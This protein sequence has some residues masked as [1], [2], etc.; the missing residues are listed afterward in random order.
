MSSPLAVAA[1]T[2]TFAQL[3]SRVIEDTALSG[4]N[5]TTVPPDV[6]A[7]SGTDRRLNLFLYQV[8]ADAAMRNEPLPVRGSDGRLRQRPVTALS[9]HYLVTAFGDNNDELD[10]HHL[11]AHAMSL[12]ND[13]P[14]LSP[15]S[16]K[17]AIAAEARVAGSDLPDQ[18][19][20]V[21]ICPEP[22][23]LDQLSKLWG[24]FQDTHYRLSVA[25]E[26]SVVLIERRHPTRSAPPV[27]RPDIRVIP[28][29]RPVI[30]SVDPPIV[31]S[32]GTLTVS[33]RNLL[34]DDVVVLV[35]GTPLTPDSLTDRRI[36]LTIPAD[37]KAGFQSVQVNHRL[38]LGQPPVPHRGFES[39]VAAFIL[40]PRLTGTV[41]TTVAR[42]AGLALTFAPTVGRTQRL[43]ALIGDREIVVPPATIGDTPV[44][45]MT[46][47]V[48][49]DF[50]T[51]TFLLRLRVDGAESQ[52][53][54][55]TNPSSPTFDQFVGPNIT[56]T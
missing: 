2:A 25:Y 46:F 49:G 34:A 8:T 32:G 36:E 50:P 53:V 3:I 48:P 28:L 16:I 41:P 12:V 24:M 47:P 45:A 19:E 14:V 23:S 5:V 43:S 56:V 54:V 37:R 10:A 52:L 11:L 20:L 13:E 39:N 7:T 26:A 21:R 9:L 51:G 55:D 29:R 33:G 1:V 44:G 18:I 6:A 40:A 15:A 4:A 30:E 27:L 42:G 22:M 38:A 31:P 17:A 35:S